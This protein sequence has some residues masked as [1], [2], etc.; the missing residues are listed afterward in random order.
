MAMASFWS[1]KRVASIRR[2]S[3]KLKLTAFCSERCSAPGD[4]VVLGHIAASSKQQP[5]PSAH[6]RGTRQAYV[7]TILTL[8]RGNGKTTPANTL[9]VPPSP[10]SAIVR[11][12]PALSIV[13]RRRPTIEGVAASCHSRR[14]HDRWESAPDVA[15]ACKPAPDP[16]SGCRC[17]ADTRRN[18]K[19]RA[20]QV[21]RRTCRSAQ[22]RMMATPTVRR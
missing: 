17:K 14:R 19:R 16:G 9:V 8:D 7:A 18:R 2:T 15:L 22:R 5:E 3:A 4:A 13:R 20:L 6:G 12:T 11:L 1:P 21:S 10:C